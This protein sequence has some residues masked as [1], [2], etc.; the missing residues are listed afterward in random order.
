MSA[1]S[2]APVDHTG[3]RVMGLDECLDLAASVPVG[4]IAFV[5]DGEV[6]VLPV[7]H[8]VDGVDVCFRTS[9]GSKL[10]AAVGHDRVAFEVDRWDAESRTG[11][12][13]LAQGTAVLVTDEQDVRRLELQAGRP[14]VHPADGAPQWVRVRT[15][16]ISGRA[17]EQPGSP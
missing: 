7:S 15:Q 4:R 6:T 11:W 10:E 14:W 2:D 12:S 13:V 3:L 8:T 5:V 9:G 16:Q 17:V 1:G